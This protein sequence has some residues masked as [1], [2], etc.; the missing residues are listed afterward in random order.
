MSDTTT[1]APSPEIVNP[2]KTPSGD[3][4]AMPCSDSSLHPLL[5]SAGEEYYRKWPEMDSAQHLAFQD[6]VMP[7]LRAAWV[8]GNLHQNAHVEARDQ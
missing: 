3:C 7:A 4:G 2:P 8:M 1:D 5:A 6:A